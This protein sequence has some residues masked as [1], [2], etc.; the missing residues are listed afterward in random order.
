M[1]TAA[2][3]SGPH[4]RLWERARACPELVVLGVLVALGAAVRFSTL[5]AQSFDSGETV[6]AARILHSS[7]AETFN[8]VATIERS[9]PLYYTV[10]WAWAH[11][12]GTGEA[13][14]RSLSAVFGTA[15]IALAFGAARELFSR[16]AALIAAALVA[17]GPDLVWYSQEARSYALFIMLSTAALW[18]FARA[19]RRPSRGA[20]AGWAAASAL[21]LASHY[22]AVFPVAAEALVLVAVIPRD[23]RRPVI[24]ATG[25]VGLAG[26]ALLPLAIHQEGTGRGNAFTN[27]PVLER[28]ASATV[29]FLAGEGPSTSGEWTAMPILSRVGGLV[30]LAVCAFAIAMLVRRGRRA[31][32]LGTWAVGAV[33]GLS[34]AAPLALALAGL[35]FVEPRNLIGSLVPLLVLAAAGLDVATRRAG[36]RGAWARWCARGRGD[37]PVRGH[38]RRD[39]HEPAPPARRLARAQ[40]SARACGSHRRDPHAAAKRRQAAA[41]LLRAPARWASDERVPARR[42]RTHHRHPE[43]ERPCAPPRQSVP[44]RLGHRDGSG[45]A[46]RHLPGPFAAEGGCC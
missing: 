5:G 37:R 29:K 4:R 31:E 12:F 45:V 14:L 9:G 1:P 2:D 46:C 36:L 8:A 6:T 24:A 26:L 34:F 30:A 11:A 7:Y 17:L 28:G 18:F 22:F 35:D 23:R 39:G 43:P 38:P 13:A 33:A 16:R 40:R 19:L 20:L 21:A 32:R 10:A 41:L 25:A 3:A 42:A 27:L 15:T 44:A